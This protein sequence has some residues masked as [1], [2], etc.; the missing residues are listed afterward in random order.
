MID[1]FLAPTAETLGAFASNPTATVVSV[2]SE[3]R[4]D[5]SIGGVVDV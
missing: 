5:S 3:G 4:R 1:D 2:R